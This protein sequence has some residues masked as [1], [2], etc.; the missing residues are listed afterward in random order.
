MSIL[1]GRNDVALL[2]QIFKFEIFEFY[3]I[4][5]QFPKITF[6]SPRKI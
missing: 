1:W 2:L 6:K 3:L 4:W 5:N